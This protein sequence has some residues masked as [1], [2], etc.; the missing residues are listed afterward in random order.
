MHKIL[1]IISFAEESLK[2]SKIESFKLDTRLIF[3]FSFQISQEDFFLNRDYIDITPKKLESFHNNVTRRANREPISHIIGKKAFFDDIFTVNGRVLS[4][5]PD[6][7]ILIETIISDYSNRLQEIKFLELGVGSGCLILTLLKIFQ[8]SLA[9]AVDISKNAIEIAKENARTLR[10]DNRIKIIKSDLFA[11]IS[12]LE[13]FDIIISNP[14][15][16]STNDIKNLEDEVKKFEPILALD[17][18]KDG[19]DFYRIIANKARNFL[20][21]DGI[22]ILEIGQGQEIDVEEIFQQNGLT[23]QKQQKDLSG[24]VRCLVFVERLN[25]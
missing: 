24:I 9:V 12:K 20:K 21:K 23:L 18:G 16:I 4:P 5:R 19:L 15:Y 14:P 6:S 10:V 2:N 25:I 17:G 22:V 13:K 11:E 1:K 7:E 3:C 8:N